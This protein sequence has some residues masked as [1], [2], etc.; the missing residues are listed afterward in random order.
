MV[1]R[2]IE[3][4]KSMNYFSDDIPYFVNRAY[5]GFYRL[6]HN[7]EFIEISCVS[8]GAGYHYIAGRQ[9]SVQRGDIFYI[10]AGTSHVFRPKSPSMEGSFVIHNCLFSRETLADL[11]SVRGVDL[12]VKQLFLPGPPAGA[13][14]HM[15]DTEGVLGPLF[16]ALHLE[17]H[18]R[19]AGFV[20]AMRSHIG[21]ILLGLYRLAT[22][23]SSGLRYTKPISYLLGRLP[24]EL[25][26]PPRLA[27]AAAFCGLGERQFSRRFKQ[28]MGMTYTEYLHKLRIDASCRLLK[29]TTL[30]I[31]EIADA[32]GYK[33]VP[34][35]QA[36]FKR[37]VGVT[38]SEYRTG[39]ADR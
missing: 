21:Q 16:H 22:E 4:S 33:D 29:D 5:E 12:A 30:R 11:L 23:S 14:L 32:M 35:F 37:M 18:E 38:P 36:L 8:E 9:F 10:P 15:T 19:R 25:A 2:A 1:H 6:E 27:E 28:A 24:Q 13:Y 39:G 31:K 26:D 7:H 17:Y 20:L 3:T 34:S